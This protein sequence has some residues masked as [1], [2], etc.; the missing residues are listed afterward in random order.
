[1]IL[2]ALTILLQDGIALAF[3]F[4]VQIAGLFLFS[5]LISWFSFDISDKKKGKSKLSSN[6]HLLRFIKS[7]GIGLLV[8]IIFSIANNFLGPQAS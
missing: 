7:V 8:T 4:L 1:M 5:S 3:F 6:E 2:R